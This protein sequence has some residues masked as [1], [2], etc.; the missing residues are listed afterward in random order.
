MPKLPQIYIYIIYM[1]FIALYLSRVEFLKRK[2][3]VC[4]VNQ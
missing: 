3:H 2:I 1:H 4:D